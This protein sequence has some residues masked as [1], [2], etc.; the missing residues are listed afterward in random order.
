MASQLLAAV[1]IGWAPLLA[2]TSNLPKAP[3]DVKPGS[4]TYEDIPYPHPVKTLPLTLYGQ[5]VR[6]AYMDAFPAGNP[7]GRQVVLLHGMNFGGFYF[8]GL[9]E[10][11][12]NEG[13]R[14]IVPDQI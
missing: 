3:A 13:F 14:V 9:I 10:S 6:M 8:A 12:R 5:D 7:N 11:L 1:I 4:I 2:Q